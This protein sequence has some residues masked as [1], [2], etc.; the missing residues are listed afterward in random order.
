MS[1][2]KNSSDESTGHSKNIARHASRTQ[3]LFAAIAYA[4]GAGN[5][6]VLPDSVA[7][8][9]VA[10]IIQFAVCYLLASVPMLYLEIGLGQFTSASPFSIYQMMS[11]AM[12]GVL[13]ELA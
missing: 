10:F 6:W 5:V 9:G 12:G 11:P 7:H 2:K 3:F 4:F 1:E 8:S 13:L